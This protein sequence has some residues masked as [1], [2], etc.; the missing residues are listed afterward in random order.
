M[1]LNKYSHSSFFVGMKYY[2]IQNY[3]KRLYAYNITEH[4]S[5]AV[6]LTKNDHMALYYYNESEKEFIYI[7]SSLM[8]LWS[9]GEWF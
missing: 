4:H 9:V 3:L 2:T 6:S 8:F 7:D 5:L 1:I